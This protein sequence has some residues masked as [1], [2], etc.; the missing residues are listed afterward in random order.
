MQSTAV[1]Y[2]SYSSA[3]SCTKSPCSQLQIVCQAICMCNCPAPL[4]AET[5][6]HDCSQSDLSMMNAAPMLCLTYMGNATQ[7]ETE[8]HCSPGSL[9]TS[10]DLAWV[11]SLG[12]C[13][14]ACQQWSRAQLA[15]VSRASLASWPVTPA[16]AVM[17]PVHSADVHELTVSY[18]LAAV[19]PKRMLARLLS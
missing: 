7:A 1:I 15:R 19:G 17:L 8:Q 2:T 13:Q 3:F 5:L 12:R 14:S 16:C 9:N 10:A 18:T 4:W 11:P 6:L